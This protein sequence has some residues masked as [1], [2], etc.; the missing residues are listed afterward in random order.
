MGNLQRDP[1]LPCQNNVWSS[2]GVLFSV[3]GE[4]T[5]Q[6]TTDSILKDFYAFLFRSENFWCRLFSM[7]VKINTDFR[8]C[9]SV[10]SSNFQLNQLIWRKGSKAWLTGSIWRGTRATLKYTITWLSILYH[11]AFESFFFFLKW[12]GKSLMFNP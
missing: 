12:H 5:L 7:I 11:F 3:V 6:V 4:T 9:F 1:S 8:F 10:N 2:D